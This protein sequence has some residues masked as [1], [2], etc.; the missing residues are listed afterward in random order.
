M[1]FRI[2]KQA[3]VSIGLQ[4]Q[5]QLRLRIES[6]RLGAGDR[7]PTARALAA[8]LEVNVNTVAAAY[9]Q[10]E[11]QGYLV[12]NRR[13]GTRIAS[14]PPVSGN[15]TLAARLS[16]EFADRLEA[17]ELDVAEV[18][19]LVMAAPESSPL[20][21]AV[22]AASPLEAE[23]AARRTRA[24]LG[25]SVRCVALTVESYQSHDYHLTVVDA[26]LVPTLRGRANVIPPYDSDSL[27]HGPDFPAGAD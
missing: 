21:V 20:R 3:P 13:A 10:L 4:L 14:N 24:V 27:V 17:L 8:R 9:R 11:S 15:L 26:G 2:D 1:E 16:R 19:P 12:T 25:D 23:R 6:G 22:V 7:L 5:A 18:L